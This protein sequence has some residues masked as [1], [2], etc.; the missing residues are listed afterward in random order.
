MSKHSPDKSGYLVCFTSIHCDVL[1]CYW[2]LYIAPLE[3]WTSRYVTLTYAFLHSCIILVRSVPALH[4]NILLYIIFCSYT[5]PALHSC[6][7]L[8]RSV[9]ALHPNVF[10]CITL[11]FS[12]VS[13]PI[14]ICIWF[15][16]MLFLFK[17]TCARTFFQK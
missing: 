14:I 9:S 15:L 4:P 5:E 6:V 16:V 7:R 12:A 3:P 13:A 17:V 10:P 11:Y 2:E 1:L 8:V